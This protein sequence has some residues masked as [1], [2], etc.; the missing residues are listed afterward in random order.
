MLKRYHQLIGGTFRL[1]DACVIGAAWLLAYALRFSVPLIEVTKGFPAF[2]TY[3]ALLPLVMFLWMIVFS[4]MGVYRPRGILRRTEEA[5][6][7][8]RSHGVALLVF[9][10]ITYLFS[11]YRYSRVVMGFF[12]ILGAVG[13]VGT[14]LVLRNLLRAIREK[15]FQQSGLLLVGESAA[16]E[17]LIPRIRKFPELGFKIQGLVAHDSTT[18]REIAGV[19]VVGVLSDLPALLKTYRPQSLVIALPREHAHALDRILSQVKDEAVNLHL[20]PDIYEYVIL[21]CAVEDFNGLPIVN[22]N[23]SPLEGWGAILKRV[24]DFILAFLGILLISPLLLLIALAVK[25]T[26]R[27]PVLYRQERMGLDGRTFGMLK[28]R[29]MREDA[30]ANGVGWTQAGDPRRTPIGA[31]LRSTSIDEL[32]QLWNVLR[33]EMSLVGPRPERPMYVEK[34]RHDIPHYMLRHKVK[35]GI[36][37][38]AQVN[39]LRGDTSLTARIEH[40]LYYIRNWS[41]LLDLKILWLTL[42]KGFI[43]RNAY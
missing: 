5:W 24:T 10:A 21:G 36:T 23:D 43:H 38:W 13:V 11:E 33:G 42:W 20:I 27:G 3:A 29:S 34:F 9:I 28:F 40:D 6:L 16:L 18:K 32:P 39:G 22:L 19:P 14:R 37:G 1:V 30:E 17:V 25:L 31:F 26:S 35:A 7:L 12:G 2:S 41:Y 4:G 8:V 15:G